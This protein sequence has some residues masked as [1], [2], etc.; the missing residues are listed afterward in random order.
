MFNTT[1]PTNDGFRHADSLS[2][3]AWRLARAAL[4]IVLLGPAVVLAQDVTESALKAAF[5][6]NFAKFTEWPSGAV[7]AAEPLVMCVLG[8]KAVSD[9]LERAVKARTLAGRTMAVWLVGPSWPEAGCQVLYVSGI[10]ASQAAALIAGMR[11]GPVL[12]ISDIDGFEELGGIAQFFFERGQLR[13][14]VHRQ[15][16]ER[17]RLRISSRL[18]ALAVSR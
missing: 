17:A 8:D 11:D 16:A 15:S 4:V 7:P 6:Y 10:P 2:S 1:Q 18:L 14:S 3:F 13:F 5:I 9:A 12:T